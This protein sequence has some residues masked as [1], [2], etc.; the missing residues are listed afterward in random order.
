MPHQADH[1]VIIIGADSA[2]LYT[3]YRLRALGV[4]N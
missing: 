3:L 2:G 4:T 1:D